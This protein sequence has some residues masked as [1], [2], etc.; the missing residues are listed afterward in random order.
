MDYG[1]L[2]ML[3]FKGKETLLLH[4]YIYIYIHTNRQ[5]IQRN[6]YQL[7]DMCLKRKQV[8]VSRPV[9]RNPSETGAAT[10]TTEVTQVP[11]EVS[12]EWILDEQ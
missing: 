4:I 6:C 11:G 3:P 1:N 12:L 9:P 10:T 7:P 5:L 8:L 2:V